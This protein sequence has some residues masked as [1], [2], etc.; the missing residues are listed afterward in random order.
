MRV[1]LLDDEH[2]ALN[3]L[4]YQ[5]LK[6]ADVEIVGKYLN[7]FTGKEKILSE[8]VDIVFLDINLPEMNGVELAEQILEKKPWLNIVFVTAYD[9]YAIQAFELNA[10][11]YVLK[12]VGTERLLKTVQ[13]IQ[14]RAGEPSSNHLLPITRPI[15]LKLFRY[16]LIESEGKQF[17]PLRW[18]TAR[19]QELFLYL[20]QHR[21]Q[22]V[23]KYALIELLWPEYE[24]SRA[25]SQLYTAVYHIR[26]TLEPFGSHFK[27][28]NSTDG[29]ILNIENVSVDVEEW[30]NQI[31]SGPP[32]TGETI[33]NYEKLMELYTGDYLQEYDY[34]WAESERHRLKLLW[35]RTSFQM[36]EWYLSCHLQKK[37]IE[38]YLE[39]CRRHPLTEEAHF[40]LMKIYASM[41]NRLSVHLQYR[42]LT[43]VL[44]EELNEQPSPYITK[45]YHRWKQE[46]KE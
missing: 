9:N 7:P 44:L 28:S 35:L 15:Q 3:Y 27:I 46:N 22:L 18:R 41:N 24:P 20:L 8:D 42:L 29:Y 19:A 38:K 30:E 17:A 45:W 26:K 13:R 2:H 31:R 33:D 40:E 1:I 25:Y 6:I 14:T 36:A 21:E 37:A 5:L 4:E 12:P 39:I 32:I 34:W 16:V 43:T 11:D 23:R 10:L